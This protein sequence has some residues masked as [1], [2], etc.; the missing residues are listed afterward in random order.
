MSESM[1]D[2]LAM[3]YHTSAEV[4]G[5]KVTFCGVLV[6]VVETEGISCEFKRV[7][8]YL[9]PQSD[10]KEDMEMI[11]KEL[12]AANRAGLKDVCKVRLQ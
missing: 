7:D 6:Q 3:N 8:G 1:Q 12:D 9:F 4:L 10:S 11:D 5:D 2:V